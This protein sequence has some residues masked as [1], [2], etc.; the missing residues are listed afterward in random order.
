MFGF[1]GPHEMIIVILI[2]VVMWI[3]GLWPVVIRGIRELRGEHVD[4][5]AY[6]N[7]HYSRQQSTTSPPSRDAEVCYKMLGISPSASW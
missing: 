5:N 7:Q 1:T 3:T 6:Q 2:I 4:D